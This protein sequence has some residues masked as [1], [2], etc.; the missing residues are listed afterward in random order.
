[1]ATPGS[2]ANY[3]SYPAWSPYLG[4]TVEEAITFHQDNRWS[5]NTYLG[6]WRF[7]AVEQG[8]TLTWQE[9]RAAPVSQ[10]AGST[11]R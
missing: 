7:M 10:D 6:P 2:F 11:L 4:T 1:M 3:G 9:W 8:R 5:H